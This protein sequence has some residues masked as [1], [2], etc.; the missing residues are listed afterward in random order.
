MEGISAID[1]FCGAGGLSQGLSE[2]GVKVVAGIDT[3]PRCKYP[4]EANIGGRF[5]EQDVQTVSGAQLNRLWGRGTV[6]VLAG[7]APC[8]PFSSYRRGVDTSREKEWS[9]LSEFGRL[10]RT[11]RPHVVTM[12]NVPRIASSTIFQTFISTLKTNGFHVSY[13][14]VYCPE[15]GLPQHRRRL[16]LLASRLGP[17]KIPDGTYAPGSFITVR[18][19]IGNLPAIENGEVDRIDSLHRS[20]NLSEINLK[21]IRASTPGG[22]WEDWPPELRAPCHRR[23]TGATFRSVYARMLWDDPSPTITTMA[24]NFGTGRFGHPSQDRAI[25]LREASILQ[26]FP[27]GYDFI[28]PGGK[29]EFAPL[30]RLIGNA[31]PPV[32]G[33]LIG[34]TI[35]EHIKDRFR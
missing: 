4:F 18:D 25:S 8:Q 6:K 9:L 35:A 10:A 29:V 21:R 13:K 17:I 22:T 11:T 24:Y 2:A 16:V 32:I 3:D 30:G 20:R 15:Y 28:P 14:S 27:L 26:G 1:L 31:V 34:A 5:L 33:K 7:C 19:A 12:E 23:A